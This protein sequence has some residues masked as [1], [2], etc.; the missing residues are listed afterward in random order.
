MFE[1]LFK[2]TRLNYAE[3]EIGF[4]AGQAAVVFGLLVV[5]LL[6]GFGLVYFLTN[7]YTG[8]RSKAVSLGLRIPVLLLLCLPLFEPVLVMPDVVPDENF[9]AVLVDASESMNI[10]DGAFGGA[11]RDD[12]RQLLFDP[13]DGV[14]APLGEHFKLRYYT[15]SGQA[16]R[17]DSLPDAR[18]DGRRTDL[19]AALDRV[20]SDFK[21]VPLAGVVLLTD[22]GDNGTGVPLNKAEELRS[23]D[24]PMHI[25]GL[26]RESFETERELLDVE[27]SKSVEEST[28][29]EIDVKVRSWAPEPQPVMFSIFQGE[30]RVFSEARRLK[31]EG[32]VD[33]LSF[34]YE[35]AGNGAQE[36]TLQIE[37]AP[38]ERN[39]ENNTL[40]LLIDT[41]KDTLRV[42]YLEGHPRRD[43]KFVRRALVD[44]QVVEFAAVS[45]TGTNKFY[46]QGIRNVDELAGG[47]PQSLEELYGYK[48]VLLGDVEASTFSLDQQRMLESFVRTRGG[49]LL[50]MGGLG[51]F[52]EGDYWNTPIE[53]V[54]PLTLDP[55]RRKVIPPRFYDPNE[56][57][58][59][60]GFVFAPTAA[61]YDS[62]I[63]KLSSDPATNRTRWGGMP[64]LTSLNY[65]GR[66]KPGAVVLAEKP[67]DDF[68]PREPLLVVHRYGKGR[69]AALPTASTWRWQMQ[70]PTEDLRHERFWRQLVR[71]LAASAPNPVDINLEQDLFSPGEEMQVTVNIY[72][73]EFRP[74]D[75]A[76]VTGRITDPTG[77]SSEVALQPALTEPGAY[78]A[79]YVPQEQG[80]YELAVT[81]EAE[82]VPVGAYT[83]SFLV[84][85]SKQEYHDATLKRPFLASLAEASNG[86]YYDVAE[87]GTLPD[88]LRGRRTSTSI[89]RAEYLWD[90]PLL[91]L[92]VIILLSAEWLYRRRK[93]MP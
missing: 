36:Y 63:L 75:A 24:I 25:V 84:R 53:D 50:M 23:L 88:N 27:V 86:I 79:T 20:I 21:G 83:R 7:L 49:G 89:Y 47:F 15:F 13:D 18:A 90:M 28:G 58:G 31:G 11:R 87:V 32:K 39:T 33:Q 12:A 54:L 71:W 68:G 38:D 65:V 61:G 29:A 17:V 57:A 56:P 40:N 45:R 41:R 43:F 37:P 64:T 69:S 4:Q 42:L 1:W 85:S 81:A 52:A 44:D 62:P 51:S 14:A 55:A 66:V 22:G 80:V 8:D 35:P 91:F 67:E 16:T 78:V 26:G 10:V 34:F 72:D 30:T 46:R 73:T 76:A 59:P 70:L 93:G 82:G 5:V 48:V 92:L 3:G 60:Q 9:V 74:L 77:L 6:V 2:F 19:T